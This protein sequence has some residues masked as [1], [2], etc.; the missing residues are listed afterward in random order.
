MSV[1]IPGMDLPTC[2]VDCPLRDNEFG[3]CN[4][5]PNSRYYTDDGTELY[6]P[7]NEKHKDCPLREYDE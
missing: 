6:N 4:L 7:F 1:I 5:I 3:C 2:C